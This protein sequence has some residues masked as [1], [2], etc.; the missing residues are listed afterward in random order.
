MAEENDWQGDQNKA[1][2][3]CWRGAQQ[4]GWKCASHLPVYSK[5][6]MTIREREITPKRHTTKREKSN[7]HA[8]T[9]TQ[10]KVLTDCYCRECKDNLVFVWRN[11]VS[12][13]R[14]KLSPNA[15]GRCQSTLY[16]NNLWPGFSVLSVSL[17]QHSYIQLFSIQGIST[18][19]VNMPATFIVS[20]ELH[21]ECPNQNTIWLYIVWNKVSIV[22][23]RGFS[24][25]ESFPDAA[26]SW[27]TWW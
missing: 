7:L 3:W 4:L 26:S 10:Y 22:S 6:L 13:A 25:M 9:Q 1:H 20:S 2:G 5:S 18:F 14:R 21:D 19:C 24:V 17:R 16:L 11:L 15:E 12:V 27:K 8:H 23:A